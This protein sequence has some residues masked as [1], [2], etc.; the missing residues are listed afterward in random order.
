MNA[1]GKTSSDPVFST[2]RIYSV[3]RVPE[4]PTCP[5]LP[6]R[7]IMSTQDVRVEALLNI[8][9]S[10]KGYHLCRSEVNVDEVFT[11]DKKRVERGSAFKVAN[12]RG[13]LG[14]LQSELVD[15]LWPLC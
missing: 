9:C 5:S 2:Q 10:A 8:R 6:F 11:A 14:H 13:Q 12:H 7:V 4:L 15:P 3:A 1:I